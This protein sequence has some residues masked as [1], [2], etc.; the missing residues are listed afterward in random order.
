MTLS[1]LGLSAGMLVGPMTIKP[2]ICHAHSVMMKAPVGEAA[3][4][5]A[6]LRNRDV[7]TWGP[8]AGAKTG[9][10]R[11]AGTSVAVTSVAASKAAWQATQDTSSR[12]ASAYRTPSMGDNAPTTRPVAA[13]VTAAPVTAARTAFVA[14]VPVAAQKPVA[15]LAAPVAYTM[16][17]VSL[18]EA[19]AKAAWLAKQETPK[20]GGKGGRKATQRKNARKASG[21]RTPSMG[22]NVPG[23]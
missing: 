9:R 19:A 11:R 14:P 22:D 6:W 4:K 16:A 21:Y 5:A 3:A 15:A 13:P 12:K 17:G 2:P 23:Y 10:A 8:K 7:P 20:W 1:F 18:G